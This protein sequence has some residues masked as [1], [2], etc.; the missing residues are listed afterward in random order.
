MH[1]LS[2]RVA[3]VTGGASGI[4]AATTRMFVE[5]GARVVFTGLEGDRGKA[6]DLEGEVGE[7]AVFVQQDV[8]SEADWHHVLET[9]EERFG[10]VHILVNNAGHPGYLKSITDATAE[11]YRRVFEVNELGTFLGMKIIAPS[12]QRAGGGS[13]VNTSSVQG[14]VG[15]AMNTDYCASKFAVTGLTKAAACDL[16][17]SNIRVNAIHPGLIRTPLAT[18][19]LE[20]FGIDVEM[21]AAQTGALIKRFGEPEEIARLIMFLASDESAFCTGASF[22]ADGGTT[23]Q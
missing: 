3:I 7:N 6:Q 5:R 13:I 22:V 17:E 8:S 23:A 16:A 21:Y 4:G 12:M 18:D 20:K 2:G 9:T 19:N 15:R 14:L 11:E 10:H 1:S